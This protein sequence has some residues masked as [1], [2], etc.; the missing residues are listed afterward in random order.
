MDY[1]VSDAYT[2]SAGAISFPS[3]YAEGYAYLQSDV[4]G[5]RRGRFYGDDQVQLWMPAHVI[6][7]D[8]IQANY[9]TGY[10]NNNLYIGLM[11]QSE[12]ETNVKVWLNPDIVPFSEDAI[13][14]VKV[15]V[16][17]QPAPAQKMKNG[18]ITVRLKPHGITGIRIRGI[19]VTPQFQQDILDS[20]SRASSP[21]LSIQDGPFGKVTGMII[22]M[23]ASLKEAYIYLQATEKDVKKA[24]LRY[25]AKDQWKSVSDS[26][27]PFEFSVPMADAQKQFQYQVE[28]INV[29]GNRKET[30]SKAVIK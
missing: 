10:G 22:D 27:Y 26:T 3:R 5:D 23:G 30:T 9:L 18:T 25:K 7:T 24:T 15:W 16:N 19:S 13:Y 17:N 20:G 29:K 2:S 4:Y 21:G 11:N 28:A 8:N 1:L 14:Q 12:E 6:R